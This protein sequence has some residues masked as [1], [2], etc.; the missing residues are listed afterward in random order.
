MA[1]PQTNTIYDRSVL[2]INRA[3]FF[4]QKL[5]KTFSNVSFIYF[6]MH[7]AR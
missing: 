5:L 4:Y 6:F 1:M 2:Y 7:F 3:K